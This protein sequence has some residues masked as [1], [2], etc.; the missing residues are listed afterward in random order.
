MNMKNSIFL[1]LGVTII[2][3]FAACKKDP[4]NVVLSTDK[5]TITKGQKVALTLTWD[6]NVKSYV[7]FRKEPNS[8]YVSIGPTA[9][10]G[11]E[12][13]FDNLTLDSAGVYS[14]YFVVY[15]C[16]AARA[17]TEDC[18]EQTKSNEVNITVTP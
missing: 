7:M 3:A 14:F 16:K 15:A 18:K 13:W 4:K 1:L 17:E 6:G 9:A 11:A 8:S 10:N 2:A 5:T 12:K